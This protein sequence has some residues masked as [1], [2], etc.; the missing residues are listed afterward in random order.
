M[1]VAKHTVVVQRIDRRGSKLRLPGLDWATMA[2]ITIG[3][4]YLSRVDPLDSRDPDPCFP[5]SWQARDP[6]HDL[7]HFQGHGLAATPRPR[8]AP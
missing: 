3:P 5:A 7:A 6:L 8:W 2:A 4:F 1:A